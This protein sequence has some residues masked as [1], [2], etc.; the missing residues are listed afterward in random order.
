[1]LA[2][3]HLEITDKAA[4]RNRAEE[5]KKKNL[6]LPYFKLFLALPQRKWWSTASAMRKSKVMTAQSNWWVHFHIVYKVNGI[7]I[8]TS[9]KYFLLLSLSS[10]LLWLLGNSQFLLQRNYS[11][12]CSAIY[13]L[14]TDWR[15]NLQWSVIE[16]TFPLICYVT[17]CNHQ[18]HP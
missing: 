8:H 1:M 7:P 16:K 14:F 11:Q 13:D 10:W 2:K 4:M 18:D 9:T 3:W 15:G 6:S 12:L 5:G 17:G